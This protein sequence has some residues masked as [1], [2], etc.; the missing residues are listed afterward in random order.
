MY[1]FFVSFEI[2][3]KRISQDVERKLTKNKNAI[4]R[5]NRSA[6]NKHGPKKPPT[7][8]KMDQLP[9]Q[10]DNGTGNGFFSFPRKF[11]PNFTAEINISVNSVPFCPR[12]YVS[13]WV[14]SDALCLSFI[15]YLYG[16]VD[17]GV[18]VLRSL[19]LGIDLNKN[20]KFTSQIGNFGIDE[21]L[22]L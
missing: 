4:S 17:W 2:W 1:Q 8:R 21:S 16:N 14:S 18:I 5:A 6:G 12:S 15:Q 11:S 3:L 22:K 7:H 9:P 20:P 19:K 10:A 13:Q